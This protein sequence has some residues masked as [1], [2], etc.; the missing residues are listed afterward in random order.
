MP[1]SHWIPTRRHLLNRRL[2]T[3]VSAA[4]SQQLND[5]WPQLRE[6]PSGILHE[7]A[8]PSSSA[9]DQ[10]RGP[11]V[12][13]HDVEFHADAGHREF[14]TR[15]QSP[16]SCWFAIDFAR[17]LADEFPSPAVHPQHSIQQS[18][19]MRSAWQLTGH[20]AAQ[21]RTSNDDRLPAA[22][23]D[24]AQDLRVRVPQPPAVRAVVLPN[25]SI[26]D[27]LLYDR[28][29]CLPV[30]AD[31]PPAELSVRQ[32]AVAAAAITLRPIA[33]AARHRPS[34]KAVR[35]SRQTAFD[36]EPSECPTAAA[37]LY[38]VDDARPADFQPSGTDW[39]IH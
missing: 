7:F 10:Y 4:R 11:E 32:S 5:H 1:I 27:W 38:A 35:K 25:E 2:P 20:A 14:V 17:N 12:P 23:D 8:R 30:P 3:F 33:T 6:L 28:A 21:P 18:L 24:A 26:P 22:A 9:D 15:R 16:H 13:L 31:A 36:S 37:A 29:Q 19:P 39:N 34:E